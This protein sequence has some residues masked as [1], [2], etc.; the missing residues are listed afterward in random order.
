ME[1]DVMNSRA[2]R[3][4]VKYLNVKEKSRAVDVT[5]VIMKAA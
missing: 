5:L 2:G 1:C 3:R 4:N